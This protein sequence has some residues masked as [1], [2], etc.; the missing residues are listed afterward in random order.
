MTD[1]NQL[2][3]IVERIER[4]ED[5]KST[6][7]M[8]IKEVY[9]EAKRNGFDAKVIRKIIAMRKQDQSKLAEEQAIIAVYMY[10]LGMLADTP[11][12]QAAIARAA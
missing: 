10:A 1:N 9:L 7:S 8:D 5:E 2:K 6:V 3:T 12:G 11:L 4:L